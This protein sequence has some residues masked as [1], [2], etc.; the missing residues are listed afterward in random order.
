MSGGWTKAGLA[1][2]A[3]VALAI[4]VFVYAE[5]DR[6]HAAEPAAV[7]PIPVIATKVQQHN[8]PII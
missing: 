4:G 7:Q 6:D 8:V 3:I 1:G 2:A 5:S